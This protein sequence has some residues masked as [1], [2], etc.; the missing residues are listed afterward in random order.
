MILGKISGKITTTGFTFKVDGNPRKLDYVQVYHKDYEYVLCQIIEIER[1]NGTTTAKCQVIGYRDSEGR[2]RP[3]RTPF[4]PDMEVLN[5]EDDFIRSVIKLDNLDRSAFMGFL[6]GK[7]IPVNLKLNKLLTK[8]VAILAKSGAGKSYTVGVLLEEI[9]DKKVPL[10]IIDPH[11]EYT[12]LRYATEDDP[13]RLAEFGISPKGFGSRVKEYGD[14]DINPELRPL[15]LSGTVSAQE[16]VHMIPAKLSGV[17]LNLLYSAVKDVDKLDFL[18]LIQHLE[19]EENNAKFSVINVIDYLDKLSIFSDN[20]TPYQEL[21]QTN[22]CTIINLKGVEPTLQEIIVYKLLTDLFELR[23]KEMIPPFFTV[24]EEAHMFCPERSFGETKA[25]K[26][27]RTI[28]SEGRKF[29]QGLCIV[30]QRPARVDKSVL[31]QCS[32]QLILKVTN[33][34]DLKA[35]SNSVEGITTDAEKEIVNL[36]VGTALITGVVDVPLFV[37]V[38]PRKSKHGGDAVDM[39]AT[40]QEFL[41]EVDDYDKKEILPVIMPKVSLKDL[42]LMGD[43]P[44]EKITTTLSPAGVFVCESSGEFRLLFDLHYGALVHDDRLQYIPD[45]ASLSSKELMV[46]KKIF[47][48]KRCTLDEL[49]REGLKAVEPALKQL[50]SKRYVLDDKDLYINDEFVFTSLVHRQTF[51]KIQFKSVSYQEML[52]KRFSKK[53]ILDRIKEFAKVTDVHD[54]FIVRHDIQ[55]RQ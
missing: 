51:A 27:L 26:I 1:N 13:S 11:G 9:I 50:I 28:A 2:V 53:D 30:S 33:P 18:T 54:C 5:A 45:L 20:P 44:V 17:Q 39:L 7:K 4:D 47:S 37:N 6:E 52:E 14:P 43:R 16:L 8:H 24:I 29:G 34:N 32:T 41:E 12:D 48:L 49:R 42:K 40:E 23:K 3:I 19:Q 31:S 38:R 55:Y 25:S 22:Q 46:L 21:V 15:R 35:I 36:T 10:L